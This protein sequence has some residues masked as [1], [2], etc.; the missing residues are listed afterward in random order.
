MSQLGEAKVEIVA[1]EVSFETV[2]TPIPKG[3]PFIEAW[4]NDLQDR[5]LAILSASVKLRN[6]W[7]SVDVLQMHYF[8]EE[9][10]TPERV[11]VSISVDSSLDYADWHTEEAEITRL[12]RSRF[13]VVDCL[14]ER[15][16]TPACMWDMWD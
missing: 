9:S 14:I 7:R 8:F 13:P 1:P 10:S 2:I 16:C 15:G 4:E 12:L 6:E 3:H 5:T 11:T